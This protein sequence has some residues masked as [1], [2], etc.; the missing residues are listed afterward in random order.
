[1]ARS[2]GM[3]TAARQR[4]PGAQSRSAA[5]DATQLPPRQTRP[6]GQLASLPQPG[7]SR[8]RQAAQASPR[9]GR[10]KKGT[11]GIDAPPKVRSRGPA[12][13][14]GGGSARVA[15]STVAG[16]IR[17]AAPALAAHPEDA[18]LEG[19]LSDEV[20]SALDGLPAGFREAVILCDL[21]DCT[22]R[23][24]AA[25]LG[26]PVGTVM[27]RLYRARRQLEAKLIGIAVERGIV[28]AS[29]TQAPTAGPAQLEHASVKRR[30]AG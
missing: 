8:P 19:R 25:R 5:H 26:C 17:R 30:K 20:S 28:R 21:E 10:S 13:G 23:D 29:N 9:R 18:Y 2:P 7:G 15:T 4:R 12:A 22:Y 27:S 16:A 14:I 3:Q 1:M 6:A 11:R 24:A